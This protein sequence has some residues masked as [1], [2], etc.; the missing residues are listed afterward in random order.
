[1]ALTVATLDAA[2]IELLS[3]A[4]SVTVDGQT[5]VQASLTGMRLMRKDLLQEQGSP[6]GFSTAI[7]QGPTH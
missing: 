5:Y 6:Y 3:G 1:M 7:L 2:I 4:Q